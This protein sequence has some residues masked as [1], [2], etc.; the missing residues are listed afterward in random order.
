MGEIQTEKKPG[1]RDRTRLAA[2]SPVKRPTRI[3][4]PQTPSALPCLAYGPNIFH[5]CLRLGRLVGSNRD[6]IQFGP[7]HFWMRRGRGRGKPVPVPGDRLLPK[8]QNAETKALSLTDV[9]RQLAGTSVIPKDQ[10]RSWCSASDLLDR[11]ERAK[12]RAWDGKIRS[13]DDWVWL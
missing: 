2:S 10:G 11:S 6:L 13:P 1:S 12:N 8:C 4:C 3:R 9:G 7:L 5:A